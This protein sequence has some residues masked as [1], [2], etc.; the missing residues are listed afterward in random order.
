[1][2]ILII[3]GRFWKYWKTYEI[4]ILNIID[5]MVKN[6]NDLCSSMPSPSLTMSYN[7]ALPTSF[8]DSNVNLRQ[9]QWKS[10]ES[11]HALWLATLWG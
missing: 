11:G 6:V 2:L 7:D 1:M 4:H 5:N 10:K 9:K 8:I 3:N